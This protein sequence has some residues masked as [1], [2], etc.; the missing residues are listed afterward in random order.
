MRR[1]H[2]A[3]KFWLQA[4]NCVL[5]FITCFVGSLPLDALEADSSKVAERA[6]AIRDFR[7]YCSSCHGIDGKGRGPVAAQ[8]KVPPADLTKLA[9]RA[10]GRFLT[11]AVYE[12]IEGLDMPAAHGTSAMPIWGYRFVLEELGDGVH[13]EDARRAAKA[14][15]RRIRGLVQYLEAIQE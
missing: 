6:S 4:Q 10:G 1:K 7:T 3:F 5:V 9:Q 14:T 15:R 2:W 8:L 11:D 12:K 13:L